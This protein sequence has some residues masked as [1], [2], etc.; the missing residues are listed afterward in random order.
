[1]NELEKLAVKA[2]EKADIG[3]MLL[4]ESFTVTW[5]NKFVRDT[6][7]DVIGKK[8]YTFTHK[9]ANPPEFCP[10]WNFLKSGGE[11]AESEFFDQNL[12][13]WFFVKAER[14]DSYIIHFIIDITEKM[15]LKREVE[16]KEEF[17]RKLVE[18]SVPIFIA[19]GEFLVFV[20]SALVDFLGYRR[21]S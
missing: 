11:R 19:Q 6:F 5:A 9:T 3:F 17:Y 12:D 15:E 8:C 20:N 4:D 13:R 10:V 16:E 18:I 2:M 14:H 21:R 1:M 7:G